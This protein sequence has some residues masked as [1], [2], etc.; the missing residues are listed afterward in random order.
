MRT[1]C[2]C[3]L[4]YEGNARFK[5][6]EIIEAFKAHVVPSSRPSASGHAGEAMCMK[7]LVGSIRS[8]VD[9]DPALK[10]MYSRRTIARKLRRGRLGLAKN[11]SRT[12][13]CEVCVTWDFVV[14]NELRGVV[15][16]FEKAVKSLVPWYFELSF[17]NEVAVDISK[18]T[19]FAAYVEFVRRHWMESGRQDEDPEREHVLQPIE[20]DFILACDKKW[21]SDK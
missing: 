4:K 11:F 8:I 1:S 7:T 21:L 2:C 6:G 12:D 15:D 5:D 9:S 18:Y 19:D 17:W 13:C 14:Q 16:T 20:H 3:N 10:K